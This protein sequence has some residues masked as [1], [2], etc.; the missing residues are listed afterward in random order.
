MQLI[1][2]N[3]A[4]DEDDTILGFTGTWV[5]AMAARVKFIHV[6]T[7]RSGRIR[8]PDNVRVYS[9]GKEKGYS[10]FRR[11]IEFYRVLFFVVKNNKITGCFSHMTP[12]FTMLAAPIL[13]KRNIPIMTWYAHPKSTLILK[14]AHHFSD[15]VITSLPSAYPYMRDKL[16]VTG[17]GIDTD[18]FKPNRVRPVKP[19]LILC[20]GRLS[21][22]KDHLTLIRAANLLQMNLNRAFQVVILGNEANPQDTPYAKALRAEV[23]ALGLEEIVH[24]EPAVQMG[25]LSAFYQ[26][27]TLHVNLTP[28]GFGD[29]VALEAMACGKPCLVANEEFS[30]TL[31]EYAN[32]LLFRHGD[33]AD[34]SNKLLTILELPEERLEQIGLRLQHRVIQLHGLGQLVDKV[35]RLF[36]PMEAGKMNV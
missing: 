28:K 16:V 9:I 23:K 6:I 11:V 15:C 2:F 12:L 32:L 36:K 13:K 18:F 34:L 27:C 21:P 30:D 29:K 22:V 4:L 10:E 31:G 25:N 7:M 5:K 24:F 20:A 26:K 3:L 8:L 19:T 1:W 35:V 17:Q 14:I 33:P